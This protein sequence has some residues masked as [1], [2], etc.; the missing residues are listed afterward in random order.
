MRR[1]FKRSP[2]SSAASD[3]SRRLVELFHLHG[4]NHVLDIGAN[5]G[6]YATRLRQAGYGGRITSFEPVADTHRQL[7]EAAKGHPSWRI[8]PP[9]ALGAAAGRMTM[10][11]SHR[12]D[13]S[14]LMP[15]APVTLEAIPRAF[16]TGRQEVEVRRLDDIF[17]EF[18]TKGDVVLAKLDTQGSE[19]AILVGAAG[20]FERLTGLQLELSLLPLYDGETTYLDILRFVEAKG[21][22]P[23]WFLPGYFSKRL[24]R[25]LQMD[26]VLF[27]AT[28]DADAQA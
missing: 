17:D 10:H 14:S 12:S 19:A 21:F 15:I 6:Q 26:A 13:M 5:L 22:A 7:L 8:A 25:Q 16:E 3:E 23:H 18:V 11:V 28:G 2:V 4:I 1:L 9:M 20:I 27:R 24:N